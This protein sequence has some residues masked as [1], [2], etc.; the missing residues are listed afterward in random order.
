VNRENERDQ[1]PGEETPRSEAPW[2]LRLYVNGRTSLKTIVTLQNI[3][4]L[5]EKHL[6]GRYKL[7]VIDLV[8]NFAQAREDHVIALPTL[9]R[10]SPLPIRKI[11][12]ELSNTEQVITGLGLPGGDPNEV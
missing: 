3:T 8:E 7:E 5:C 4:D 6:P 9:V 1:N 11:I 12:G 10:R 2:L